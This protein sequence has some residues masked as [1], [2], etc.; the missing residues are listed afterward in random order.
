MEEQK[1]V[2]GSMGL[3]DGQTFPHYSRIREPNYHDASGVFDGPCDATINGV[4]SLY[5]NGTQYCFDLVRSDTV[6]CFT[7]HTSQLKNYFIRCL[8]RNQQTNHPVRVFVDYK[9][10]NCLDRPHAGIRYRGL[11]HVYFED[12]AFFTFVHVASATIQD[13][14]FYYHGTMFRSLREVCA[15]GLF[16]RLNMQFVYE[17]VA[18]Q[19]VDKMYTPDFWL[20]QLGL[21]VEVKPDFPKPHEFDT[22]RHASLLG[23]RILFCHGNPSTHF[24]F[25]LM[26]QD[27]GNNY[28]LDPQYITIVP[29]HGHRYEFVHGCDTLTDEVQDAYLQISFEFEKRKLNLMQD[30]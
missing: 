12:K 5:L 18:L 22:A 6:G 4:T 24:R 21:Y 27:S 13:H 30:E 10:R 19:L 15:A 3:V 28:V 25:H 26:T 17:P 23:H 14:P 16:E 29:D 11:Y 7:L 20:P 1:K 2:F 8:Q 9:Q